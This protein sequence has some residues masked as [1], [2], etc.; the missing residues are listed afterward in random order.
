[1]ALPFLKSAIAVLDASRGP[2][3]ADAIVERAVRR[4]LLD[5]E[6]TDA[7]AATMKAAAPSEATFRI[8]RA[9]T[10]RPL[11]TPCAADGYNT[12][13][14]RTRATARPSGHANA[15]R[16]RHCR[17]SRAGSADSVRMRKLG[18]RST[19]TLPHAPRNP[20][21][22]DEDVSGPSSA[23]RGAGSIRVE[24]AVR[25]HRV[26]RSADRS[27]RRSNLHCA[28]ASPTRIGRPR[29]KA[30]TGRKAVSAKRSRQSRTA[31]LQDCEPRQIRTES[32]WRGCPYQRHQSA[33]MAEF[34][35]LKR[36]REASTR[37][38]IA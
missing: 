7:A 9:F 1:M 22:A 18:L 38:R 34:T 36:S 35:S 14:E 8:L 24:E 10:A 17:R 12:C 6:A 16:R 23:R 20:G 25:K 13:R 19:G 28:G 5:C 21:S 11:E 29:R 32:R 30:M 33:F 31:P 3:A 15:A 37:D 26:R 27:R 4:G 2:L